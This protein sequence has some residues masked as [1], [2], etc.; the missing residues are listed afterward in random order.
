MKNF[1][2]K[3]DGLRPLELQWCA[4]SILT[5]F[6]LFKKMKKEKLISCLHLD[7]VMHQLVVLV[8][9]KKRR[10]KVVIRSQAFYP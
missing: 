7:A 9:R 6:I 3:M 1:T 10:K 4:Y 5:K 8:V 2:E